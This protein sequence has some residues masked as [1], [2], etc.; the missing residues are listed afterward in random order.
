[1]HRELSNIDHAFRPPRVASLYLL[2]GLLL[3]NTLFAAPIESLF[4]VG[5]MG[6]GAIAYLVFRRTA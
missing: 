1:M 5:V 6:H 2:A 3:A 4:G